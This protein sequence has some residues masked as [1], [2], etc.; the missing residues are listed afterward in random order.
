M[1]PEIGKVVDALRQIKDELHHLVCPRINLHL[2]LKG[3]EKDGNIEI[4]WSFCLKSFADLQTIVPPFNLVGAPGLRVSSQVDRYLSKRCH[5]AK[6]I[7][8]F[9]EL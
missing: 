8:S 4:I 1:L 3:Q 6:C 2:I 7:H 5:R 9:L